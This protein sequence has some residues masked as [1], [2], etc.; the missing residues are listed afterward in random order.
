[1]KK[2][3]LKILFFMLLVIVGCGSEKE[4]EQIQGE[5]S[6]DIEEE[7]KD[8][9]S[10]QKVTEILEEC[11]LEKTYRV[12]MEDIYIDVPTYQEIEEGYTEVFIIHGSRYVALTTLFGED[13]KD[14]K[15][16]HEKAFE[17]LIQNM[18]NYEGGVNS[19]SISKDEVVTVNGIEAYWFEG[20]INYGEDTPHDGYAVG[21]AF[22]MDGIPCEILGS[23]IEAEQSQELI[24]EIKEIVDEM[25]KSVRS[26]L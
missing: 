11:L 20:T 19:I 22:I 6:S 18:Q 24:D 25:M 4:Q 1:M 14:V 7:K 10:S 2:I 9:D 5:I 12:P 3:I 21:Y 17:K 8:E 16:A 13:I 15:E 26:E 23:V